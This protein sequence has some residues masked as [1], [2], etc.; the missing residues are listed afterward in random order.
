MLSGLTKIFHKQP[1]VEKFNPK[2][3]AKKTIFTICLSFSVF[4]SSTSW[5]VAFVPKL[6]LSAVSV[7]VKYTLIFVISRYCC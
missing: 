1:L 6:T 7:A 5:Q 4:K 3:T 2:S